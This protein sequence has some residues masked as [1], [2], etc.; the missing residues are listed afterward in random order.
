MSAFTPE[1]ILQGPSGRWYHDGVDV[2][3]R[4]VWWLCP[5]GHSWQASLAERE[6]GTECPR[7]EAGPRS[8]TRRHR[9]C[10][11]GRR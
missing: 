7:C 8:R 5:A 3:D 9:T 2:T 10:R 6:A 4:P 1:N 11:R